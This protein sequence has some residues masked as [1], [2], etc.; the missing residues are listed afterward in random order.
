MTKLIE[1]PRFTLIIEDAKSIAIG[2]GITVTGAALTYLSEYVG[3]TNFG[4]YTPLIVTV[5]AL[6]VNLARKFL[7]EKQYIK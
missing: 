2:L 5:W 1:S 6:I 3:K 7:T 4:V